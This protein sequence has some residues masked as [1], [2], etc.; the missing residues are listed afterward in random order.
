MKIGNRL[1]GSKHP[2]YI[3]AE[4]S[5]NHLGQ[6]SRAH[7]IVE[8]AA[9]VG[10]DAVKLQTYTPDTMTIKCDNE[11]FQIRKGPWKG[12]NLYDLYE[13]A[14]MPWEWTGELQ[15]HAHDLGIE[16]LS[17]AYDATAVD[18]LEKFDVPAY[19]VASFELNDIEL[20]KRIAE[21]GKPVIAS[22]GMASYSDIG[23]ALYALRNHG[24]WDRWSENIAFLRCVSSYPAPVGEMNLDTMRHIRGSF[25]VMV[26]L[27][28]HSMSIE[29][30][31]AAAAMGA[32]II[33]K[34]MTLKRSDGGQ[35]SHFS[36]EP[37]EFHQMVEAVKV[38]R[39]AVGV[40]TYGAPFSQKDSITFRRS[41]FV[42]EDIKK[43][44][45]FTRENVR[46]IRPGN[47]MQPIHIGEV[48][49]KR[50]KE[51]IEKGTPLHWNLI[52]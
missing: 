14:A 2:V 25:G 39:S 13:K 11:Y 42:V 6:L 4:M 51:D 3:I 49:G 40:A 10:A 15:K 23:H 47:G 45:K 26:G 29:V 30:P 33:E 36:L 48:I 8:E 5:S 46:S 52:S 27:S 20:L 34:H 17:T 32:D 9:L 12:W 31:V 1:M 44:E 43:G 22:T 50:A 38:A 18:F 41:L 28:D 35:D 7:D 24:T 21:T 16:L 19:K 37:G